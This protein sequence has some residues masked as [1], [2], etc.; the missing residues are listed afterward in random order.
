MSSAY[1]CHID[2]AYCFYCEEYAPVV[3]ENERLRK[4][5]DRWR[6]DAKEAN[7]LVAEMNGECVGYMEEN[8]RL[9]SALERMDDRKNPMLPRSIMARIAKEALD[10]D[11]N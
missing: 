5:R 8:E 9:R 4:E 10:Y 2:G 7:L 6:S 3:A 11:G 1:Q